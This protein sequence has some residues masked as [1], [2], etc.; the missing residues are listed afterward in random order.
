MRGREIE[1]SVPRTDFP[2]VTGGLTTIDATKQVFVLDEVPHEWLFP[3]V[4]AVVHHGGAGTTATALRAGKP[5]I[6]CPLLGD[7][8]FWAAWS[9]SVG[10]DRGR[11]LKSSCRLNDGP[12]PSQRL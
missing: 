11:L 8:A 10:L 5:T 7:Q 9:T 3:Q 2:H 1:R 4:A 6:I 12:T